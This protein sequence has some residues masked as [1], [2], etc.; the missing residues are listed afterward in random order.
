LYFSSSGIVKA[1]G[2]NAERSGERLYMLDARVDPDRTLGT[3]RINHSENRPVFTNGFRQVLNRSV[4]ENAELRTRKPG[5]RI[6]PFGTSGSKSLSD[7]LTD[8][9]I[10]RPLRD[11]IPLLAKGRD[12]LWVIGVGISNQAALNPESDAVE[13]T[14]IPK[15]DG[16]ASHDE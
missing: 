5:D 13:L 15:H 10:D 11:R 9:K 12:I 7:Y 8:R 1:A 2:M 3:L 16:G 4:V 6:S 14:Y